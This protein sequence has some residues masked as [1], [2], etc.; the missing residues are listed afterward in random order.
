M[1]QMLSQEE[2]NALLKGVSEGEIE[3]GQEEEVC[4]PSAVRSYD[5]TSQ[6]GIVKGRIPAMEM[7]AEKFA[8]I[9]RV[10]LMSLLRK[11]V[12]IN[13]SSVDMIKYGEF[14]QTVLLPASLHIFRMDPLK[15][16]AL[17]V[18]ESQ[19]IFTWIDIIF[20]GSGRETFKVEGREFTNIENNLVKKVVLSALSDLE[21]AWKLL[22]NLNIVYQGSEI[23][24]RFA[25]IVALGDVVIVMKFEVEMEFSSG[26]M[27]LCIPYSTIEPIREKLQTGY[28]SE[29]LEV[30]EKWTIRFEEGLKLSNVNLSVELGSAE[31]SGREIIN[32]KKGDVILLD[33]CCSDSLD[34]YI[35][36]VHKFKGRP[37]IYKGN[38]AVQI[39]QFI[40][41]GKVCDGTE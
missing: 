25:Q 30:D 18:V 32:L 4:D 38:R 13:T 28:L 20:G 26:I 12:N 41:G 8:R 24:P 16:S 2:V 7:T 14:L 39:S 9:F 23:N 33:R 1:S 17:F 36:G 10:T 27:T 3:M 5:L 6:D 40:V 34:I 35:E 21:K 31:L 19:V 29:K 22:V 15:G 11:V 37:G